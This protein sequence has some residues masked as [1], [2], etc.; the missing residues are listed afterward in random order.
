MSHTAAGA[1]A[2]IS[3]QGALSDRQMGHLASGLP[4][5][6]ESLCTRCGLCVEACPCGAI[7]LG[8]GGP[9]FD[10]SELSQRSIECRDSG[11]GCCMY[12]CE[13]VC[14]TGAIRCSFEI[15]IGDDEHVEL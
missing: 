2:I 14:P 10:C 15:V 12:L 13:E 7:R 4:Q 5:V 8:E 3:V 1:T 9:V 11:H 6:D